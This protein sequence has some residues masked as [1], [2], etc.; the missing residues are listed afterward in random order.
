MHPS[1][2]RWVDT[3]YDDLEFTVKTAWESEKTLAEDNE[4]QQIF[5]FVLRAGFRY[6]YCRLLMRAVKCQKMYVFRLLRCV[7]EVV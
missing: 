4:K 5:L 6:N 2:R 1:W 3:R 7:L